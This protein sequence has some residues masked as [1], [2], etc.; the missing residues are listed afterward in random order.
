VPLTSTAVRRRSSVIAAWLGRALALLVPV[1]AGACGTSRPDDCSVSCGP[2]AA[3]PSDSVCGSDGYCHAGDTVD[4]SALCD[5]DG[6]AGVSP[7][8]DA[9]PG[10]PGADAGGV[11]HDGDP[12]ASDAA[13]PTSS[14]GGGPAVCDIF[15]QTG[16]P[17][18]LACDIS[19]D[20]FGTVC[21][22]IE[23]PGAD[24]PRCAAPEECAAG[25]T[26][27][28]FEGVCRRFCESDGECAGGPGDYCVLESGLGPLTC[29]SDCV[30][31]TN[32]GCLPGW[33]CVVYAQDAPLLIT[34]CVPAGTKA[35]GDPCSSVY[36]ECAPGY[37]CY[38]D[39]FGDGHC[40]ALCRVGDATCPADTT[41]ES[42]DPP[43]YLDGVEY[44][45][46]Q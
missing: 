3:C 10:E 39:L 16:C 27:E 5:R 37:N 18:G 30:P 24:G 11:A 9:R 26:C 7:R 19:R 12:G 6:D 32:E 33:A 40:F 17:D 38:E 44:G 8:A 46:C 4:P 2:G 45:A 42:Y 43:G 35:Q 22:A 28:L 23:P 25:E 15:D 21:R 1:A 14:D 29:T 20:G 13:A 31:V 36:D 41:C 34:D